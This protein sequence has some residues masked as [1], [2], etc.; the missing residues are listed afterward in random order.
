MR[1]RNTTKTL[2]RSMTA[3]KALLR[4]LATSVIVYEK[5]KTTETKA[6]SVRPVVER[7]I[8]RAKKGDL[9]IVV[10]ELLQTRKQTTL[11]SRKLT[12]EKVFENL[13]KGDGCGI[14]QLESSG[15]QDLMK[16]LK[17]TLFE[18]II[19]LVALYR[20][21]PMDLIPDFIERK[22]GR[23]KVDCLDPR[24]ESILGPTYGIMVY[25][26]Q[27]MLLARALAGFTRGDSDVL[28]KA[29]G[30]KKIDLMNK[31]EV[32]FKEGCVEHSG[33]DPV[34]VDKLWDDI[35]KF[36]EYSFNKSHAAAY[37]LISYR[38]AY[39]K[40]YYPVEFFAATISS[41]TRDPDKLAF[42]LESAR[43][44]GIK[45]LHPD[46]NTS[47]EDFGV[48]EVDG[49]KVIRVGLSGVKNVGGEA[50]VK[51]MEKRPYNSYQDFV[52]RVDLSKVNK[53]VCHSLISVGAFD[54]LGINRA[55]LLEVYDRVT[56]SVNST[57]R[58]KTLFG[59]GFA[60]VVE[61]PD[62]P[63]MKMKDKL[64]LE[65]ELLGV[66]VSGHA[67]D[68]FA[69]SKNGDFTPYSSLKDDM[70]AEVFGLVKRVSNI[71]T[72]NGDDMA[73]MD[74]G[75]RDG[76]LKVTVF[77]RDYNECLREAPVKE[78]DGIRISGKFK[79]NEEF[80]DAFIAKNIMVCKPVDDER[81]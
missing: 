64:S 33:M 12:T 43:Q 37:A 5:I 67:T 45:I 47:G 35:V 6:K 51:I 80:G 52:N 81:E 62:L 27:V 57:E 1:H 36:A 3:R 56:P 74:I 4:D 49:E 44:E 15:M 28:R 20:P 21:G 25:Q 61:Y 14:F 2:G 78:G 46:I 18:D 70:E 9:G 30:K 26:E 41:A 63:P 39:L 76:D 11:F 71:V 50:M 54:E 40:K 24:L 8:T 19:A 72:K 23:Q 59:E 22:H 79:K 77:P 53:R 42:Y 65:E 31:M 34:K 16:R 7:L 60:D 66:C 13:S 38:T 32:Q 10:E 73:F 48:V 69:E 68:A 17:P 55:S 58:Q 75:S 29:I